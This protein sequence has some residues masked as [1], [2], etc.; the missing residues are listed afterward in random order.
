MSSVAH[1]DIT[2][3]VLDVSNDGRSDKGQTCDGEDDLEGRRAITADR[4]DDCK[5]ID[6]QEDKDP[7]V[8]KREGQVQEDD[9]QQSLGIILIL[10]A[11]V[12]KRNCPSGEK[13]CK[14]RQKRLA[15]ALHVAKSRLWFFFKYQELLLIVIALLGHGECSR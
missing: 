14:Q 11:I 9:L 2:L 8:V 3:L 5:E 1:T 6:D 13:Q 12:D 7:G 4:R 15:R 10:E